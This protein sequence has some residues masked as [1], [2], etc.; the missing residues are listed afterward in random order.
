M[1]GGERTMTGSHDHDGQ[2]SGEYA[3]PPCFMH[4]VDPA[5]MGVVDAQQQIDVARWRKGERTR[6]IEARLAMSAA[7]R[8]SHTEAIIQR[9]D[10]LVGDVSGKIVS[11]YWPIRGEPDLRAWLETIWARGGEGALPIVVAKGQPLIF[12]TWRQGEALE[13]GVWNIPVPANGPD[14]HPD[15][16]ISPIV[17]FDRSCYRLGYGGGYFDR[18][19]AAA[20]TRPQVIGIGYSTMELPTIYPQP[21]DIPMDVIVTEREIVRR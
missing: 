20:K 1:I 18:T 11:A 7:E 10:E 15:I 6:R 8:Q 4:E 17:G 3:S 5:Y 2:G 9:I 12:R 19:L 21:H 13:K 16:V 14:V